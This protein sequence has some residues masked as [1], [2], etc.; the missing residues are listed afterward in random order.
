MTPPL[1]TDPVQH[2]RWILPTVL[3]FVAAALAGIS[4][5]FRRWWQQRRTQAPASARRDSQLPADA[6]VSI[7]RRFLR[8]Q[9][10]RHRASIREYPT[11][12]VLGPAGAGKS[13]LID[14][15]VDWQ[16]Q[17][18]RFFPS[19]TEEPLLQVYMGS[20]VTVQEL[21][22]A[23]L[24]DDSADARRALTKLWR[25]SASKRA[26]GVLLVLDALALGNGAPE[27]LRRQAQLIRGKID[28]LQELHGRPLRVSLC[29]THMDGFSG[30]GE[31]AAVSAR[32]QLPL[33]VPLRPLAAQRDGREVRLFAGRE[34]YLGL[35][36]TASPSE[37][38]SRVVEMMSSSGGL[39]ASLAAFLAPLVEKS[40]LSAPPE[41]DRLFFCAPGAET[42]RVFV[43]PTP[44][45]RPGLLARRQL[46]RLVAAGGVATL[47]LG[48]AYCNHAR[49]LEDAHAAV[50]EYAERAARPAAASSGELR[51]ALERAD[52]SLTS[53]H[54]AENW[55][56]LLKLSAR[57]HKRQLATQLTTSTRNA[58]LLP[59]LR[60]GATPASPVTF[61][62]A[63]GASRVAFDSRELTLYTLGLVYAARE[64]ALGEWIAPRARHWATNLGVPE[65]AVSAYVHWSEHAWSEP[66]SLSVGAGDNDPTLSLK[67][68]SEFLA[69]LQAA[70]DGQDVGADLQPLQA[71]AAALADALDRSRKFSEVPTLLQLLPPLAPIDV[72]ALVRAPRREEA[73][74]WVV[75]NRLQLEGLLGMIRDGDLSPA[76]LGRMTLG[77]LLAQANKLITSGG[78]DAYAIKL[79]RAYSFGRQRWSEMMA[80]AAIAIYVRQPGYPFLPR[81]AAPA[82]SDGSAPD[83]ARAP[84]APADVYHRVVVDGTVRPALDDFGKKLPASSL[85]AADKATLAAY[86]L[87][88][89]NAYAQR[90]R[91]ALFA[92]YQ[93][94]HLGARTAAELPPALTQLIQPSG[95][96]L[97]W[98]HALAEDADLGNLDSP[99]L[100]PLADAVAPL[101]PIVHL[102]KPGKDAGPGELGKYLAMVTKLSRELAGTER[103]NGPSGMYASAAPMPGSS[104]GAPVANDAGGGAGGDGMQRLLSPVGRVA[105]TMILQ[106][107]QSYVAQAN[108]WLAEV[109]ISDDLKAP[110]LEPF[111]RVLDFG[112]GELEAALKQQ[113]TRTWSQVSPMFGKY[114]FHRRATRE[115]EPS[116]LEAFKE[117]GGSFWQ[118]FRELAPFCVQRGETWS[119]RTP[120]LRPVNL[121][122][123]MLAR[124][125][126]I[127]RL[128]RAYFDKDG[129][130]APLALTVTPLPLPRDLD[131]EGYVTM[132][133]LRAGGAT[134]FGFNQ[135][136]TARAFS[137]SWWGGDGAS[138]GIMFGDPDLKGTPDRSVD[139][140]SSPWSLYRL[141]EKASVVGDTAVWTLPGDGARRRTVPVRFVLRGD[142]VALHPWT[143]FSSA[144]D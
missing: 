75:E 61:G 52:G 3:M 125:N 116:E 141:I 77:A 62:E 39:G 81:D 104:F 73:M 20:R 13:Q 49:K 12:L 85:P 97:R 56:P 74:A 129:K 43:V 123:G 35:A 1:T 54:A 16:A 51:A 55:W 34:D 32:H 7:W 132:S 6:L 31:L 63:S 110:F 58:Y 111:D 91:E 50:A 22:A 107:D 131:R 106:P 92:T 101:Q 41:L 108:Q 14:A 112:V 140:P 103:N 119:A 78:S 60:P 15:Q 76:R 130:R 28:L 8:G 38:F 98:L 72:N 65:T 135:Q 33:A 83:P 25:A 94:Y 117:S 37:S 139:S 44:A 102:V 18:K 93:P 86:A 124:V 95:G 48:A 100:R 53:L 17:K 79:D 27:E 40:R 105:M 99:Y 109:G 23:L 143:L 69:Q 68:W 138:I 96:F 70:Y 5:F 137:P 144:K 19:V 42:D 122:A 47:L 126:L 127:A 64:N 57:A 142:A 10:W 29:L 71:K 133:F 134:V 66:V 11:V 36:L 30:F 89:A 121:P 82:P 84:A 87:E 24:V 59:L 128:A 115:V 120:L 80:R 90:Y 45:A 2:A 88:Q 46:M 136:P 118:A 4:L 113:W 9:P 21:S 26:P 67:P 114:P